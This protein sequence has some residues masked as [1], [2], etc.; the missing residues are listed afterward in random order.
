MNK[1]EK[2]F[3]VL[4]YK[5]E[6]NTSKRMVYV[7]GKISQVAI[8]KVEKAYTA[9]RTASVTVPMMI[10]FELHQALNETFKELG[11]FE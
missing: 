6:E 2:M 9:S 11:W 8:N 10:S 1:A 3:R 4:G 5:L 7:K